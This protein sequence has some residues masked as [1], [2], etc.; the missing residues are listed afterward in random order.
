VP[1]ELRGPGGELHAGAGIVLASSLPAAPAPA[2]EFPLKP[3]PMTADKAYAEVLFHGEDMR[4]IRSVA[5][6]SEKG[7]VLDAAAALPPASWMRGAPRD[8][9]LAEPAALD[10]A[11]QGLILWT[12][13]DSGACSLPNA[14]ASYR[15]Y[16]GFPDKGTRVKV[17]VTRS[18]EH[19]CSADIDF[20]DGEGRLAARL[21]GY[22]STV[23][24]ALNAAFRRK[25][26]SPTAG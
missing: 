1:A 19:A 17:R 20:T 13:G 5:G 14:A 26:L 9:W 4:F 12:F 25:E 6:F 7:I 8:H 21:E 15:Q 22:E 18:A 10:A 2:P 3:Y 16:A 11:F 24:S 23:D